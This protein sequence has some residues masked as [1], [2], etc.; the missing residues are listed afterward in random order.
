MLQNGNECDTYSAWQGVVKGV[1]FELMTSQ[2]T[3]HKKGI[4]PRW[5]PAN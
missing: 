5:P 1:A 4:N 3:T 2:I